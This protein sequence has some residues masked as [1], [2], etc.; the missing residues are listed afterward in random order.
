MQVV[1]VL[2]VLEHPP[3]DEQHGRHGDPLAGVDAYKDLPLTLYQHKILYSCKY[4]PPSM[5]TFF[6]PLAPFPSRWIPITFIGRSSK[7]LPMSYTF[8]TC[9][10]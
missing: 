1:D 5:K 4:E 2:A 8:A 9:I 10:N 3:D 6:H 7:L